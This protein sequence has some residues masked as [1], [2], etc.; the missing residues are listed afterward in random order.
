M[1]DPQGRT[2]DKDLPL[3]GTHP[4][5]SGQSEKRPLYFDQ[6]LFKFSSII[7]LYDIFVYLS[8]NIFQI[9]PN[10]Q[11]G[12]VCKNRNRPRTNLRGPGTVYWN[13][14][15]LPTVGDSYMLPKNA[16]MRSP[17]WATGSA[18]MSSQW[19]S[20]SFLNQLTCRLAKRLMA[21][22]SSPVRASRVGSSP[23]R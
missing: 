2:T 3:H 17:A 10:L 19:T 4:A 21:R 11:R 23:V 7:V 6:V 8:T 20:R 9:F 12:S 22:P 16:S 5:L 13:A 15:I 14:V 1:A 18:A